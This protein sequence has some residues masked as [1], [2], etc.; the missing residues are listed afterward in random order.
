MKTKPNQLKNAFILIAFGVILMWALNNLNTI[1]SVLIVAFSIASPFMIGIAIAF[2]MNVPM[3]F[4]ERTLFKRLP[5]KIKR[6]INYII[7]LFLFVFII[8]ITLFIVVP[9]LYN[10][11]QELA[12]R[13]PQTWNNF[14]SWFETTTLTE[15]EYIDNFVND[16][17]LDWR[18][19]EQQGLNLL[20][21]RAYDWLLST[22]SAATSVVGTITSIVIGFVFSI[23]LLLQKEKLISQA[24]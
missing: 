13:V 10:S 22:F 11:I 2:I 3:R 8:F 6:P 21:T 5:Q 12:N 15:N 4:F 17:R 16:I 9:E 7:T 20:S 14:L 1:W 23:Y 18:S 19:I 24:K